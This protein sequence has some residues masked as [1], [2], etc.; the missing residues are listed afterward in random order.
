[1]M[2]LIVESTF[3]SLT[4]FIFFEFGFILSLGE[5]YLSNHEKTN[6]GYG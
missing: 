4:G 5:G 2:L 3:P 1:M 6:E